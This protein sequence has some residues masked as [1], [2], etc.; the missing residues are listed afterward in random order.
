MDRGVDKKG[1][2]WGKIWKG[3]LSEHPKR[4]ETLGPFP[5]RESEA[6]MSTGKAGVLV[7]LGQRA[8]DVRAEG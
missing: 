5:F 4:R 8:K 3:L 6:H 7:Q 1:S 2:T